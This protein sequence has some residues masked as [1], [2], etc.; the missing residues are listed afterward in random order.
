MPV[1]LGETRKEGPGPTPVPVRK[2]Y[3][4]VEEPFASSE[5]RAVRVPGAV[6][7]KFTVMTQVAVPP[8]QELDG[9]GLTDDSTAETVKSPALGPPRVSEAAGDPPA[10]F[11]SWMLEVWV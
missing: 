6:G 4:P 11:A 10:I 5:S 9:F 2:M 1:G 7:V 3:W 8:G